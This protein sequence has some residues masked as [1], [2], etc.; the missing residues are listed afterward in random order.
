L[1]NK[2]SH[3]GS[4]EWE[5]VL[6]NDNVESLSAEILSMTVRLQSGA[7]SSETAD[8]KGRVMLVI[9]GLD[10]ALAAN[11]KGFPPVAIGEALMDLREVWQINNPIT[12]SLHTRNTQL[13]SSLT[14]AT[15]LHSS[16]PLCRRT[17]TQSARHITRKE[18][19]IFL[20]K[21]STSSRPND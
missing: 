18:S 2:K 5:K 3:P 15:L 12:L 10:L 4:G 21:Y 14:P 11:P 6:K 16:H 1:Q 7:G 19:R 8:A 9:D 13:I 20:N 17:P